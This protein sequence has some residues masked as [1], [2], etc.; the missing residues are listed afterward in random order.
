MKMSNY[1]YKGSEE[2]VTTLN[3]KKYSSGKLRIITDTI[4]EDSVH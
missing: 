4:W 2:V 3:K 1:G